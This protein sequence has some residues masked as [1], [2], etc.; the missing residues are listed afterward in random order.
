MSSNNAADNA[1]VKQSG[2]STSDHRWLGNAAGMYGLGFDFDKTSG[3]ETIMR[4]VGSECRNLDP[5]GGRGLD[6]DRVAPNDKGG[7]VDNRDWSF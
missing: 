5:D 2:C 4:A 7:V 6:A 1:L 3:A